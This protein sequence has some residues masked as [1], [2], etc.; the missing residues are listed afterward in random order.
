MVPPFLSTPTRGM[1]GQ[2]VD[3]IFTPSPDPA[4]WRGVRQA[5]TCSGEGGVVWPCAPAL[6]PPL[7]VRLG[8]GW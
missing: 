5:E 4:P 3:T 2:Q 1:V 7:L 8:L 6:A